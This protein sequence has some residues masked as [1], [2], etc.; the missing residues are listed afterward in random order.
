M[1]IGVKNFHQK[2]SSYRLLLLLYQLLRPN[3]RGVL[4]DFPTN[5]SNYCSFPITSAA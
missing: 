5:L 1:K 2:D 3:L 4:C